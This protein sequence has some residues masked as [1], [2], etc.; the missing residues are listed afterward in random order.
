MIYLRFLHYDQF[1]ST[2]KQP[3]ATVCFKAVTV[4]QSSR[5]KKSAEHVIA[6]VNIMKSSP[7]AGC[8]LLHHT[9]NYT[10][11]EIFKEVHY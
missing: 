11:V 9:K 8:N 10:N 4:A 5:C 6:G 1:S 7:E 3:C 2:V